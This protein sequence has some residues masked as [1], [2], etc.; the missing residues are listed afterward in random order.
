LFPKPPDRES[1]LFSFL[2]RKEDK[3]F[4]LALSLPDK[5]KTALEA[6]TEAVAKRIKA[7]RLADKSEFGC[8]TVN[9]YL[10]DELA[11]DSDDGENVQGR[12]EGGEE[13][14]EQ[15]SAFLPR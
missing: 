4:L 2:K 5:V 12:E 13:I 15:A 6:G 8:W 3:K 9:K 14:E 10:S 7:I 1:V 11:S